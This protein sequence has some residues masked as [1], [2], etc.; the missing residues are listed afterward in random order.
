[1]M[2]I[3]EAVLGCERLILILGLVG[4]GRAVPAWELIWQAGPMVK[5][6]LLILAVFSILAWAIIGF[7]F[8][9][10]RRAQKESKLF[11]KA[12]WAGDSMDQVA[13]STKR[14]DATP[15]SH[16]FRAGMA[17]LNQ[18]RRGRKQDEDS[19]VLGLSFSEMGLENLERSLRQAATSELNRLTRFLTFLATTGSTAPFI[20][21]FGTVW[22]IMN[23]FQQISAAKGA[24]FDVVGRGISEALIATAAGLA[25]AIPAVVAYNYFL[26]GI[27]SIQTEVDNFQDEFINIIE[28]HYLKKR[29]RTDD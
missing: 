13:V 15:L 4:E 1:M 9:Q 17:E 2:H 25:A 7:K 10:I 28:R 23:S 19:S 11:L 27:K 12:F 29:Q 22:G 8:F 20:G 24:G 5:F 6:V 3:E 16:I 21:L 14:F 18:I 26:A